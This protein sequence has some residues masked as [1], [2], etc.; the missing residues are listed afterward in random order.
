[1]SDKILE[2][3]LRLQHDEAMALASECDRLDLMPL[4]PEPYQ[5][6]H[7]RFH[8]KGLIRGADGN[9]READCFDVGILLPSDYLRTLDP[10]RILRILGPRETF[11][12]N[13][14]A[15]LICPGWV[16]PGMP[17]TDLI[18]Q[19]YEIL[20]YQKFSLHDGLDAEAGDWARRN[21]D[22]FPVDPRPLKRRPVRLTIR[23]TPSGGEAEE[24]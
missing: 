9:V 13:I 19:A 3:F 16:T 2:A 12:P 15:P 10:F 20:T 14:R 8:C 4:G 7:A 24:S 18:Y 21:L 22:R 1:M 17:L 5:R 11:H 23:R 6:Y